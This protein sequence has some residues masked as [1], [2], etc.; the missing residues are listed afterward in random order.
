M[1][2]LM[3]T[4]GNNCF[5]NVECRNPFTKL[6]LQRLRYRGFT[7]SF[8]DLFRDLGSKQYWWGLSEQGSEANNV[9]SLGAMPFS[10]RE[11]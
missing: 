4:H 3:Q 11:Q 6:K 7:R 2:I 9:E 8:G 10:F 5:H 1:I